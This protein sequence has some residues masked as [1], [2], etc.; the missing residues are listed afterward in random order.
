MKKFSIRL[1]MLAALVSI[2]C[3]AYTPKMIHHLAT[4][5]VT[6]ATAAR[7]A[8]TAKAA[9]CFY[10]FMEPGDLIDD[11][12]DLSYQI[13][14]MEIMTGGWVDTDPAGGIL[15]ESGYASPNLPHPYN[16]QVGLYLHI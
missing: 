14:Q 4:R 10:W 11:F 6:A 5:A 2:A 3:S 15:L 13:T 1:L 7:A 8:K 12:A 9:Q 16:P